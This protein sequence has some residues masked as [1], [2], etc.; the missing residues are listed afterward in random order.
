MKWNN[1]EQSFLNTGI[2]SQIFLPLLVWF[3]VSLLNILKT[4]NNFFTLFFNPINVLFGILFFVFIIYHLH[5]E[6][7]YL[8][9]INVKKNKYKQII[10]NCVNITTYTMIFFV[11]LSILKLHF[12]SI[13]IV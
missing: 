8:I 7:I 11:I 13:F 12:N 10:K 6:I 3:I 4:E 5:C 2:K 9:N 1:K